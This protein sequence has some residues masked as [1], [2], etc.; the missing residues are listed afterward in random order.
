MKDRGHAAGNEKKYS[1]LSLNQNGSAVIITVLIVSMLVALVVEFA[2]EVF[3]DTAAL[4]NWTNAQKASLIAKSGQTLFSE[5]INMIKSDNTLSEI[6]YPVEKDLGPNTQLILKI[7][8]ENAKFNVNSIIYQNGTVNKQT[9]ASLQKLFEYLNINAKLADAIADWIDSDSEPMEGLSDSEVNSKN[10]P[11]QILDELKLVPGLDKNIFETIKP[12]LT[13]YGNGI[14][15]INTA[16]LP[17]LVSFK[18]MT[19]ALAKSII[20]YRESTP[21]ENTGQMANISGM[22]S[23]Q[24]SL[25]GKTS[26]KSR[27]F[28]VTAIATVND[29]TRIIESVMDTS[30]TIQFW[31]EQ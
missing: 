10:A 4:S 16:G 29:I 28:R 8:D 17:V 21:F 24:I 25:V 12:Y 18:D 20:S 11:L 1:A 9:L 23:I 15:N 7:E 14:V 3:I 22:G 27:N 13:V 30:G 19:E 26:V 5:Y 6:E 2:Y 31:R